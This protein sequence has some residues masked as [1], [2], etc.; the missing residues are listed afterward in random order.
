MELCPST[1]RRLLWLA[2]LL[3]WIAS[4][5]LSTESPVENAAARID[6]VTIFTDRATVRR[7]QNV[8]LSGSQ[9]ILRFTDLPQAA[10]ADSI[11]ASAKGVEIASVS[12]RPAQR[13]EDPALIDHPLKKRIAALEA[14]IRQE[15]DRQ[16]NYREQLKV[17]ASFGQM[18]ASQAERDVRQSANAVAS[19]TEMLRFLDKSR[20]DYLEKIQ[21]SE[22]A[23]SDLRQQLKAANEQFA[24]ITMTR[25]RSAIEVDIV[26]TGKPGSS[27]SVALDYTVGGVSWKGIYDLHGSSEGGDFRLD[28]RAAVRQA[29]GEEWNNVQVTLSTARPSAGL[30]PGLLKP[31]RISGSNLWTMTAEEKKEESAGE[32]S[33]G[34]METSEG[35]SFTIQ[36]PLRETIASDNADHRITLQS[37]VLKGSVEHVATPSLSGFVYLKARLRNTSTMP[38]VWGTM[39]IFLDGSFAGSTVP[40]R[41][42]VGEEF[43]VHLGPDQ[44]MTV[45][46]TLLKGDVADAGILSNKVRIENQWQIEVTNHSKRARRVTVFDRYPVARD[47]AISTTLLGSSR[48]DLKADAGG[49]LAVPVDVLAG[50]SAKFDFS[51][52]L[53]IPQETWRRFE[54][55]AAPEGPADD[56]SRAAPNAP[57]KARRMYDLERMLQH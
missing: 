21:K 56:G 4:P 39:N 41:A 55:A 54:E 47:P 43:D 53:E 23:A 46:R 48:R 29:T 11:R 28:V 57:A 44:R 8:S 30:S 18:G 10:A 3:F 52:S 24:R 32:S 17:L 6:S 20:S 42:A 33:A 2:L 35:A 37:T 16:A 50:G 34:R 14:E 49:I 15:T 19:M 1:T 26:C 36:L 38:L 25:Q 51:Y 22:Q 40:A 7:V 5:A 45:Q 13:I 27:G 12:V 31:W 9:K